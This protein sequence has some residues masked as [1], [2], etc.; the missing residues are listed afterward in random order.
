MASRSLRGGM[1]FGGSAGSRRIS[2][3]APIRHIDLSLIPIVLLLTAAGCVAVRSASAPLLVAQ[4]SDPNLLLKRQLIYVSI[5]SIV[6]IISLLVDYRQIRDYAPIAFGVCVVLL[7]VVLTPL[8]HRTAGAQ[9]WINFGVLQIQP[10]EITKVFIIAALAALLARDRGI[11]GLAQVLV[12]IGVV[13]IPGLLVFLQPDLGTVMVFFAITFAILLVAGIQLR[14]LMLVL[15]AGMVV[16]GLAVQVGVLKEYQIARLT[17]F[18]D[19]KADPQRTGFN[20]AQS[21][22]AIGSGG[23][24]GRGGGANASQTNL[25]YVPEQHTDFIFT[26]IGEENGFVGGV[27]ILGLF[28]LLLWRSLRIAM[29]SKDQFGTLLAVGVAGMIAFQLFV[30]V[31]MTVGIMPIT[32]IPLPFVSYGGS[33]LITSFFGI[34]LLM[35]VHMRRFV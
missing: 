15:V 18:L 28:A 34:G 22:I 6:F 31:G 3:K 12:S 26:A 14:W 32:G 9:R 27:A 16:L 19:T 24:A 1:D 29:L 7:I 30:N 11:H 4:G 2:S 10:A 5:A 23:W 35:N 20:L 17:A 13:V 21:K 8:G 33:S 25:A